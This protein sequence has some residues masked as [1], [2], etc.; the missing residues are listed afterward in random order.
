MQ[1]LHIHGHQDIIHWY[2]IFVPLV[3]FVNFKFKLFKL[4]ILSEDNQVTFTTGENNIFE[5]KFHHKVVQHYHIRV[6]DEAKF[7][8]KK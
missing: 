3:H 8:L 5:L 1:H 6:H 4:W 7:Y 2:S